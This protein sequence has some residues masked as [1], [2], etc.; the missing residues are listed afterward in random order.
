MANSR[1]YDQLIDS[2]DIRAHL[3][4]LGFE[5]T[6]TDKAYII[7]RCSRL[8]PEE[9]RQ[10]WEELM[11]GSGDPALDVLPAVGDALCRVGPDADWNDLTE[12]EQQLACILSDFEF[13]FPCPFVPGELLHHAGGFRGVLDRHPLRFLFCE[14][15]LGL[16]VCEYQDAADRQTQGRFPLFDLMRMSTYL[17]G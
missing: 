7:W 11:I 12:E 17:R 14:E 15:S 6:P 16:A 9:R 5:Y 4:G 3:R 2:P 1:F 10:L 13:T 8:T